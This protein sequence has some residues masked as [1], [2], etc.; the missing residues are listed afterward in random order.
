MVN[1]LP[2]S[3]EYT[4][5]ASF[6][7]V[8]APGID[9]VSY[10][11]EDFV[12]ARIWGATGNSF[13]NYNE[14]AFPEGMYDNPKFGDIG[15]DYF[16]ATD[17]GEKAYCLYFFADTLPTVTPPDNWEAN[18][19]DLSAWD[20]FTIEDSKKYALIYHYL[21]N[22]LW[23]PNDLYH[24]DYGIGLSC[25]FSW[26][27]IGVDIMNNPSVGP[28]FGTWAQS[29]TN[30]IV[31]NLNYD[32]ILQIFADAEQ[33]AITNPDKLEGE[34]IIYWD[35]QCYEKKSQPMIKTKVWEQSSGKLII[36][37]QSSY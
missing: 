36:V 18:G 3:A 1:I 26:T 11:G 2:A 21:Q 13:Y 4:T 27:V 23:D 35:D 14:G 12:P 34:T 31:G 7:L 8:T 6:Q 10:P 16:I 22:N 25:A 37:K 30:V 17:G 5:K 29:Y 32:Q 9:M 20:G 15:G 28:A 24:D 19:S 33:Y